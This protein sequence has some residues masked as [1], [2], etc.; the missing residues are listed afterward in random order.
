[1]LHPLSLLIYSGFVVILGDSNGAVSHYSTTLRISIAGRALHPFVNSIT[2]KPCLN[3]NY[4][5]SF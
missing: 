1:M 5:K 2:A 3:N 4:V